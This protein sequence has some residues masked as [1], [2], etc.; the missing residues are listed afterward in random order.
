MD[1]LGAILLSL[2][3]LLGAFQ[4]YLA[5]A[6]VAAEWRWKRRRRMRA[7]VAPLPPSLPVQPWPHWVPP[8]ETERKPP[9]PRRQPH[10]T[11][12][13]GIPL[14]GPFRRRR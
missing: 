6:P 1:V 3:G 8:G 13:R 12:A 10:G 11:P 9:R 2:A 4:I 5:L 7:A 14:D